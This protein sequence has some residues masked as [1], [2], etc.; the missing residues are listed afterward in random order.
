MIYRCSSRVL[1]PRQTRYHPCVIGRPD[2]NTNR[3]VRS[4]NSTGYFL[5]LAMTSG[6]SLR[7]A[8]PGNE[9]SVKPGRAHS[10][11]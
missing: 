5:A 1:A 3:V 4:N 9:A 6:F 8:N 2:S 11:E 10:H 7:Q